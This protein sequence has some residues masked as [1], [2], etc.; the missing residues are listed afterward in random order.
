MKMKKLILT[1]TVAIAAV[2]SQAASVSWTSGKLFTAE[3]ATGG[4]STTEIGKNASA[5]LF[6]LTSTQYADF[7]E[8][9]KSSG[10]MS[11]VYEAYKDSLGSASVTGA[12][13][14]RTSLSTLTT[15]ADKGT[16]VYGAIIYTYTDATLGKDFYIANIATGTVGS[17]AGLGLSNL[18]TYYLGDSTGTSIGGWQVEGGAVPE[19]TSGVLVLVGLAGLALRRKR[20]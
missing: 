1:A 3:S 16:T 15:D 7:L 4:F 2:A 18:G 12:T 13:G 19:P 20:A 17:D 10:N 14:N 11:K 5:Y 8:S 6:T 9:Y